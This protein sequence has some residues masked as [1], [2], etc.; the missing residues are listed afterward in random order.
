MQA[1][2]QHRIGGPEVLRLEQLPDLAPAVGQA[3]IA[4]RAAGVHLL[5]VALREG[6]DGPFPTPPLPYVPGREVAGVVDAVGPGVDT[7]WVGRQVAVHLGMAH[8]GYASQAVAPVEALIPLTDRTSLAEAVAMVGTG[9]TAMGILAEAA[10]TADDTVLIPAAAGGLGSLLVQAA[11]RAGATVVGLAS[12]PDKVARVAALGADLALD[13]HADDWPDRLTHHRLTVVLDGVGGAIG[14]R[15]FELLAPG[16]RIVLFGYT[17]GTPTDVTGAELMT[18]GLSASSAL[19]PRMMARPG[20]IQA[21]AVAA[22]AELE[23]G[24]LTPLV[25]EF[26]LADAGRAH[27]ALTNRETVGKVVLIP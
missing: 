19:G 6:G 25:T 15:A 9:R 2:R 4:V 12:G 18:R 11:R 16:G 1:I 17:S 3:R 8:G 24:R 23:A 27:A 10:L 13:Y 14:R 22:V 26:A 21:L 20:G 7:A 5:D